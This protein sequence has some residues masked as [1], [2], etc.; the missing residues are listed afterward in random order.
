METNR[1]AYG[2]SDQPNDD[3]DDSSE[4]SVGTSRS[5]FAN[6]TDVRGW[7]SEL[8]PFGVRPSLSYIDELRTGIWEMRDDSPVIS[9]YSGCSSEDEDGERRLLVNRGDVTESP[10]THSVGRDA[11]QEEGHDINVRAL[12]AVTSLLYRVNSSRALSPNSSRALSPNS[13]RALSPNSSRALS[14][15]SSRALRPNSSRALS[16][17]SSP[18]PRPNSSP[19]PRPNS[20]PVPRPNSSRVIRPNS[21]PV[22]RPNSSPVIRPN[23]TSALRPH[24][25]AIRAASS[26]TSRSLTASQPKILIRSTAASRGRAVVQGRMVC[27][28]ERHG[29]RSPSTL[30]RTSSVVSPAYRR[31]KAVTGSIARSSTC[32]DLISL[33]RRQNDT[34]TSAGAMFSRAPRPQTNAT[35][36]RHATYTVSRVSGLTIPVN[37]VNHSRTSGESMGHPKTAEHLKTLKHNLTKECLSKHSFYSRGSCPSRG[38]SQEKNANKA[39]RSF[40]RIPRPSTGSNRVFTDGLPSKQSAN[41]KPLRLSKTALSLN[42]YGR[43]TESKFIGRA[44]G[45]GVISSISFT[46]INPTTNIQRPTINITDEELVTKTAPTQQTKEEISKEIMSSNASK[47]KAKSKAESQTKPK[48]AA[49]PRKAFAES[50]TTFQSLKVGQNRS[51]IPMRSRCYRLTNAQRLKHSRTK[52]IIGTTSTSGAT[53]PFTTTGGFGGAKVIGPNGEIAKQRHLLAKKFAVMWRLC[54]L[55]GE[56]ICHANKG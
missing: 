19:V 30:K 14:P 53:A 35:R 21:S 32:C 41:E 8:A 5:V 22:P 54:V 33:R 20:S 12:R 13:S 17:N 37:G 40:T 38:A 51:G 42:T 36:K 45:V 55:E 9:E 47:I 29:P 31:A 48:T 25:N 28:V 56:M 3:D 44:N 1:S 23:S 2:F 16:P 50:Y 4:T 6:V 10:Q 11:V 24:N 15:N 34:P 26:F 52:L 7:H 39:T 43:K 46:V 18:V 49:D 27:K